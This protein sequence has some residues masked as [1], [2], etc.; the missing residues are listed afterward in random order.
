M[1]Q[2]PISRDDPRDAHLLAALRHAPDRDVRPPAQI[3]AAILGQA[4]ESLRPRPAGWPAWRESLRSAFARLWQPAPMAAFGTLALATL[5]GV[6]WGGQ[7]VPDATPSLRPAPAVAPPAPASAV[8]GLA[9]APPPPES[10]RADAKVAAPLPTARAIA[11]AKPAAA[12]KAVDAGAQQGAAQER[13]DQP[14]TTGT[15]VAEAVPAPA[16][17][18]PAAARVAEA[19]PQR[20]ARGASLTDAMPAAARARSEA[21]A[22]AIGANAGPNARAG[23]APLASVGA[24]IDAVVNSEPARVRWRVAAQRLVAHDA[25]QRQWWSTLVQATQGR[26]QTAAP[27]SASGAESEPM[28]LLIDGAPRGSLSF[29]P[30]AVVWRDANGAAWRA[31]IAAETLRGWQEAL[32][33]W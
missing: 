1:S 20:E 8:G 23:A 28:T 27:G 2:Q 5:I 19:P 15:T 11:A 10:T 29:E 17:Q 18:A 3:T 24:E 4:R 16:T 32:A 30:Q 26:W 9:V 12:T 25:A 31:P 33:R 13:H 21:A 22:P 14:E 6:M 7:D